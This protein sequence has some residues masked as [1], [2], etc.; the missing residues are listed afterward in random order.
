M[1]NCICV[2]NPPSCHAASAKRGSGCSAP[3]NSC[4][5]PTKN[6]SH[7]ASLCEGDILPPRYEHKM[8]PRAQTITF[9]N[10]KIVEY[11]SEKNKKYFYEPTCNCKKPNVA[12]KVK[13]H[14][15]EISC[16]NCPFNLVMHTAV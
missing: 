11:R 15:D 8:S 1:G 6:G 10:G 9:E 13:F 4:S 12:I 7:S 5:L 3:S 2:K 14:H 16:E